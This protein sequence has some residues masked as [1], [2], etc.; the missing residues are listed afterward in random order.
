MKYS[1]DYAG[2]SF[3]G[4]VRLENQDQY[5]IVDQVSQ[6]NATD[7]NVFSGK[8]KQRRQGLFAIFDGMGGE[9]EG[10]TASH[11]AAE[12]FSHFNHAPGSHPLPDTLYH[13]MSDINDES[14][15][16]AVNKHYQAMGTTVAGLYFDHSKVWVFNIG[17]SR[18]YQIRNKTITQLTTDHVL[19]TPYLANRPLTQY[20]GIPK[21]HFVIEPCI[22]DYALQNKD[23]YLI[24][25]D[26]LTNLISDNEIRR[27][28]V[29]AETLES[30][31]TS[32][33]EDVLEQ[34]A[35][36]NAT[37][38]LLRVNFRSQFPFFFF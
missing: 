2:I 11:L 19:M 30:A 32:L 36:D 28:I 22:H 7:T 5:C 16:Y 17:D 8:I 18:V 21:E 9:S 15:Q 33:R 1:I 24:C 35:P 25:S 34:G 23:Y 3:R 6:K 13:L 14:C 12:H 20:L 27:E 37:M 29:H 26:G 31:V 4:S 10:G 38:I